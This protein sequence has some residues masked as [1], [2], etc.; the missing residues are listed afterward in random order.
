MSSLCLLAAGMLAEV[1]LPPVTP[2]DV[3][4]P[5]LQNLSF[6]NTLTADFS[7]LSAGLPKLV[8]DGIEPLPEFGQPV[9][10]ANGDRRL[11]RELVA[12]QL[13]E[14]QVGAI[15]TLA[16]DS[17]SHRT[18]NGNR[19]VNANLTADPN[20]NANLLTAEQW[21]D[22]LVP[23]TPGRAAVNSQ[24]VS[25]ETFGNPVLLNRPRSG[26]QLYHQRLAAL[27]AG[28]VYTRLA[29][30]SFESTWMNASGHPG[31][32][33]WKN[34]LAQEARAVAKG[35]GNNRLGVV[36][37]DS[38]SM[39]LPANGL[40]KDTLWLNQGIS[41]DTTSG[42]LQRVSAFAE[43]RPDVI[44]V[45]AGIND[46]RRGAS[47]ATI[48]ANLRQIVRKLQRQHPNAQ[49]ILQSILPTRF[50]ALPSQRIYRLNQDLAA[51]A[52]A[53]GAQFMDLTYYFMDGQGVLRRDLTTDGLHL[54]ARGYQVW[55]NI[56]QQADAQLAQ[57]RKRPLPA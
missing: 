5:L 23:R 20:A 8:P 14:T 36:V 24:P 22:D 7:C 52:L 25:P 29:P 44:Y 38:L 11:T 31:Y 57:A 1:P 21:L 54:N 55:Q 49:I 34:L 43:T 39:W 18:T 3:P 35:Q 26:I 2:P 6:R 47:D 46:L 41:G 16:V 48:Q 15:A 51:I 19:W 50:A 4:F 30:D 17:P 40:P 56:L 13:P 45:M 32:A 9:N 53:E 27:Q 28:Y 42:I 33:H 10:Q 37:G 12:Q